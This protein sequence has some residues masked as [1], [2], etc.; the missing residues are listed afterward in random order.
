MP[1]H[2][3]I[4]I[5]VLHDNATPYH[6]NAGTFL[7]PPPLVKLDVGDTI[8]FSVTPEGSSFSIVFPGLSPFP[9]NTITEAT[10]PADRVFTYSGHYHY[11]V[12][13]ML[14]EKLG[15]GTFRITGCPEMEGP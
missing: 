4:R 6:G 14:P 9:V 15:G 2:R 3:T 5:H 11:H 13:V 8:N 12:S 10:P 1:Q 7:G